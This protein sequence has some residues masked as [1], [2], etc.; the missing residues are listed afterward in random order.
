[1]GGI[2]IIILSNTNVVYIL[3][4]SKLILRKGEKK[5]VYLPPGG[6]DGC[7]GATPCPEKKF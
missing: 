2:C 7:C 3:H 6:D 5:I 4:N 1:L